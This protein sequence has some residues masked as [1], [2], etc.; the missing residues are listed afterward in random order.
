MVTLRNEGEIVLGLFLAV[1]AGFLNGSW[2]VSFRPS[3]GCAVPR[4]HAATEE[5]GT[6]TTTAADV[7]YHQAWILFQLYASVVNVPICLF[8][9]GGPSRVAD[10]LRASST[11][12][13]LLVSLFS[14]LWGVGS[15]G[16][17]VACTLVG[18]GLGTNLLMG[19]I[20]VLGTFLPLCLDG[21]I[22]SPAGGLVVAGLA[23]C[24][25]GLGWAVQSLQARDCDERKATKES[26]ETS[27]HSNLENNHQDG[28]PVH[29]D[30]TT[31][32]YSTTYKVA[33][34]VVAGIFATQ[35]Q[36]AFVFGQDM[37]DT[38]SDLDDV[39]ASGN[40]AVI[41]LFALTLGTPASIVYGVY[42]HPSKE[43]PWSRL[44]TCP[45]YRHL[46]VLLTTSI[47]WVSHIHLYGFST[48]LLPDDLA[49]SV[50]WPILMMMTVVT[51]MLWS[52]VLGEWTHASARSKRKLY[53]G[54]GAVTAGVVLIMSSVSL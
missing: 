41:W 15:V 34:C 16:F 38:A 31:T 54:L 14:L 1:L 37:I 6:T 25:L 10:I 36:F 43:V 52:I 32:T 12:D 17:G 30:I 26:V 47:P 27:E 23:V 13:I 42:N 20:M 2:N 8:W 18:V 21:A 28:T 35:L 46:G 11:V 50:A 49:A 22:A 39:P 9:A 4:R 29:Q 24:C 51:G 33:I 40:N 53:Q 3:R 48:T 44:Y 19:V 7:T 5:D 45:W